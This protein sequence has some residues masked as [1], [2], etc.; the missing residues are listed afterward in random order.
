NLSA[1]EDYIKLIKD[2][3]KHNQ[4]IED[5]VST[6]NIT[7]NHPEFA[8]AYE[9]CTRNPI[10][11]IKLNDYYIVDEDGRHRVAAAQSID[12]NVKLTADVREA[13]KTN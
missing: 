2:L 10:R 8:N 7:N 5:G 6:E 3:N 1:K 9:A 12:E 4:L 13:N 11:L